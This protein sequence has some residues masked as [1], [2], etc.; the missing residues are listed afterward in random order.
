MKAA[1]F[2]VA[3]ALTACSAPGSSLGTLPSESSSAPRGTNDILGGAPSAR[4]SLMLYDAPVTGIP[5]LKVN[6]GIE[7]WQ[8]VTATG[9]A[10]PFETNS[11]ADVVNLLDLQQN[12]KTYTGAAPIGAYSAARLLV[13]AKT[14]NV[15]IGNMT[16]PILWGTPG[17]VST[18]SVVAVDFP[19]TFVVTGLLGKGPQISLDF[20]VLHSVKFA[21]GAIYVQPVVAAANAAAE[22]EGT[23]QNQAGKPVASAAVLAVDALGHVVNST[24]TSSNGSYT[25]HALAAGV[26]SIQ[27]KN[28][29]VTAAGETITATGAD[30]GATP[31]TT[32]ILAPN[33]DVDL[34]ALVD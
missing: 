24:V 34:P 21:N 20:N 3:L 22:V 1:L 28:S 32:V 19:C 2:L 27:V 8:L 10:V 23:V 31:A 30:A 9:M 14:S 12:A 15:K 33:E 6:I 18:A 13:D 16:I 5:G 11:H 17:H 25:I 7:G 4:M 26:Y 29:Y